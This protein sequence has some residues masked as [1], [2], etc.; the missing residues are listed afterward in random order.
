MC[1]DTCLTILP[2]SVARPGGI[3]DK[4]QC[5]Q[6][7]EHFATYRGLEVSRATTLLVLVRCHVDIRKQILHKCALQ[8]LSKWR[9]YKILDPYQISTIF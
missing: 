1:I 4:I 9:I 5:G 3:S 6:C 2:F 7:K 8:Y